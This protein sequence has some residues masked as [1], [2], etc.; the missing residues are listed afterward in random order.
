VFREVVLDTPIQYIKKVRLAKARE[1]INGGERVSEAAEAVGYKS[2]S[3]FSREFKRYYQ[4][5][6]LQDKS[7]EIA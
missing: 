7:S 5:T 6:P 1:R 4:F 3:Q 2:V